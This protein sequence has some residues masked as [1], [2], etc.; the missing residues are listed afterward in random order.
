MVERYQGKQDGALQ[1]G[2]FSLGSNLSWRQSGPSQLKN[3]FYLSLNYLKEFKI[4]GLAEKEI[5][6]EITFIWKTYLQDQT[7][8]QSS[9]L[10][11]NCPPPLRGP[12]SHPVPWLRMAYKLQLPDCIGILCLHG[13]PIHAK[14]NLSIFFPFNLSFISLILDQLKNL[15]ERM[16]KFAP[17]V[18]RYSPTFII[19]KLKLNIKGFFPHITLMKQK[20]PKAVMDVEKSPLLLWG[21]V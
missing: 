16:K 2:H 6:P 12:H 21:R 7:N 10:P 8:I 4:E 11:V 13:S 17:K 15:E 14:L 19:K 5:L 18:E 1:N 3:D 20:R 9:Y